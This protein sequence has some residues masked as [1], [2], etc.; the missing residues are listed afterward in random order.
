[1]VARGRLV[2][3]SRGEP[4]RLL[5]TIIDVTDTRR[6]AEQRLSA[7]QR[8]TAI[9]EVAAE[10]ANAAQMEDLPEIVQRGASARRE[11]SALAIFDPDPGRCG[12]T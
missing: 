5:G 4:V 8:A 2:S 7:M 1:M 11:S 3:D 6:Q 9:A 12:C 10:L